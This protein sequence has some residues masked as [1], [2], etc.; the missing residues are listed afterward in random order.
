MRTNPTLHNLEDVLANLP[1]MLGYVPAS[2]LIAITTHRPDNRD[3][4]VRMVAATDINTAPA[5]LTG[6]ARGCGISAQNTVGAVLV[7]VGEQSLHQQARALLDAARESLI[8]VGVPVYRRIITESLTTAGRWIDVDNNDTGATVAYHDAVLTAQ[9]VLDGRVIAAS[10]EELVG[11]LAETDPAPITAAPRL[12]GLVTADL[13]DELG[14]VIA[15]APAAA[16]LA[17]RVGVA[18][19][20]GVKT[21]DALL[22]AG[23]EEPQAAAAVWTR[24]AAQLRGASRIEA[25]VVVAALH[26]VAYDVVRAGVALE[27]ADNLACDLEIAFPRLGGLLVA[28]LQGGISPAKAREV[29]TTAAGRQ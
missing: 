17:T 29:F 22:L 25:L 13:S 2:R 20:S 27:T 7:S 19:S 23:V 1:A 4:I 10:R 24:I 28:A 3:E 26:Y 11:E 5:K 12:D 6:F 21:R 14:R 16:D 9:S 15:G 8:D 18:I